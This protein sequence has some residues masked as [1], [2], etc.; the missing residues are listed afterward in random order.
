MP[1]IPLLICGMAL[2]RSVFRLDRPRSQY[3]CF[4]LICLQLTVTLAHW[5]LMDVRE[6]EYRLSTGRMFE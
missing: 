4:L 3:V 2:G 5:S 6:S 1:F